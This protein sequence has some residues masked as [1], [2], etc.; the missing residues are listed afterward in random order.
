MMAKVNTT[1]RSFLNVRRRTIG[2]PLIFAGINICLSVPRDGGC[3]LSATQ[4]EDW[5]VFGV[6]AMPREPRQTDA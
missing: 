4:D 6:R 2:R 3:N 5:E 1:Q